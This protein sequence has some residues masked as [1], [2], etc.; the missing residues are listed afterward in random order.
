MTHEWWPFG[1]QEF[2]TAFVAFLAGAQKRMTDYYRKNYPTRPSVPVLEIDTAI[3]GKYIRLVKVDGLSRSAFGFV[4]TLNGDVLKADGW[5]RP[6]KGVRGNI[7]DSNHGLGR[8]SPY[9]VQ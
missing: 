7:F 2:A 9:S 1:T 3:P 8:A 6:A 4:S 5:K